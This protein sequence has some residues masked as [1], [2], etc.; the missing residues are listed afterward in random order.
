[1]FGAIICPQA[2]WAPSPVGLIYAH[3]SKKL[4]Q[5][6][7]LPD[8]AYEAPPNA[9]NHRKIGVSSAVVTSNR[10]DVCIDEPLAGEGNSVLPRAMMGEGCFCETTPHPSGFAAPPLRPLPQGE[11]A[12]QWTPHSRLGQ[13]TKREASLAST[14]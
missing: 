14:F 9:R 3:I 2:R 7:N 1:M 10:E 6:K 8:T 4:S 13:H 5:T 11:R 12:H